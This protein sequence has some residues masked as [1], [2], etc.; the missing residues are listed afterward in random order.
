LDARL[1]ASSTPVDARSINA[2]GL[3]TPEKV[4]WTMKRLSER[5]RSPARLHESTRDLTK[6][7]LKNL[8]T[9]A[10]AHKKKMLR[11]VAA[12]DFGKIDA[13]HECLQLREKLRDAEDKL[14]QSERELAA[15]R[16]E[17]AVV[18][19]EMNEQ[20]IEKKKAVSLPS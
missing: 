6:K 7:Q 9:L 14:A 10:A 12:T 11:D 18:R 19:H 17:L 20:E 5:Y 2:L 8:H 3:E 13:E 1:K 15:T 16:A 4:E